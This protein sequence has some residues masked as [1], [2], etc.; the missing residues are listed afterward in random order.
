MSTILETGVWAMTVQGTCSWLPDIA[1]TVGRVRTTTAA[2]LGLS[3][4]RDEGP[5]WALD[6]PV[7]EGRLPVD[8]GRG[9]AL[10]WPV[11]CPQPTAFITVTAK[12]VAIKPPR[13]SLRR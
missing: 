10:G 4:R 9:W 6:W 1:V 5:N 3:T 12:R 2:V 8:E 11:D 7:G 13:H